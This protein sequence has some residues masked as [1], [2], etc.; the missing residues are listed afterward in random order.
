MCDPK[1]K[2]NSLR[3]PCVDATHR[4]AAFQSGHMLRLTQ[5]GVSVVNSIFY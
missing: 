1:P 5:N 2:K 4:A 3:S